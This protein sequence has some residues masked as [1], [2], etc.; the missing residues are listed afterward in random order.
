MCFVPCQKPECERPLDFNFLYFRATL[1]QS[2]HGKCKEK[3]IPKP[4]IIS[5]NI[6]E[7]NH[8]LPLT[9]TDKVI[10]LNLVDFLE[11]GWLSFQPLLPS[12]TWPNV[13]WLQKVVSN[14]QGAPNTL[15]KRHEIGVSVTGFRILYFFLKN[16]CG[17]QGG[18]IS[19]IFATITLDPLYFEVHI[20]SDTLDPP[21][22]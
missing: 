19:A 8:R 22:V 2:L 17:A 11:I 7:H 18:P 10:F 16:Y 6:A 1:K 12:S 13:V 20:F 5:D 9:V 15:G 4:L 14:P 3:L 21:Y